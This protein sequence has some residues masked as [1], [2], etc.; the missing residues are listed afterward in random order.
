M[1]AKSHLPAKVCPVCGRA[2]TW[3]RKWKNHWQSVKY[4]SRRCRGRRW[5]N[6][7]GA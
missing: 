3:R 6:A 1:P 4:C 2:F 7:R 5:V